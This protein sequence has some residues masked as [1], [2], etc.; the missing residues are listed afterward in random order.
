MGEELESIKS[1]HWHVR[2][3]CSDSYDGDAQTSVDNWREIDSVLSYLFNMGSQRPLA[4]A[5]VRSR[6]L[7]TYNPAR[8]ARDPEGEY[9]PPS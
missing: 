2:R 8:P 3:M 1:L 5:P 9:T 4:S 6:P 7:R